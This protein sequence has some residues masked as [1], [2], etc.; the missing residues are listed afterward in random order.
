MTNDQEPI[1]INKDTRMLQQAVVD[2]RERLH[3]LIE[4]EALSAQLTRAR[5]DALGKAGF[6]KEEALKLCQK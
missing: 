1:P 3:L 4:Y 5:Y 2:M 6:T